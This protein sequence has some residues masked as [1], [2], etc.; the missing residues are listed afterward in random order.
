MVVLTRGLATLSV[1]AV[2]IKQNN[3]ERSF[4]SSRKWRAGRA[5]SH[6][7][8]AHPSDSQSQ[9][10]IQRPGWPS[11]PLSM[12]LFLVLLVGFS[13]FHA[14]CCWSASFT[15]KPAFLAHFATYRGRH[16]VLIL[17]GSFL[18]TLMAL[19]AGWGCRA[20]SGV[21]GLFPL[22]PVNAHRDA[23]DE[24]ERLG[25]FREDR[26]EHAMVGN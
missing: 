10:P 13:L 25:V 19:I 7:I 22:H 16:R 24:R 15:A 26:C 4:L 5:Y 18:I 1:P 6:R 21:P 20:F 9:V 23:V 11:M 17:M 2:W 14:G 12:K 3:H 8:L